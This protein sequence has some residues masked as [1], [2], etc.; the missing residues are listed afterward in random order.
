MSG[1]KQKV[2][3][4][5]QILGF[6]FSLAFLALVLLGGKYA[7]HQA[8]PYAVVCFGLSQGNFISLWNTAMGLAIVFGFAVLVYS[9]FYGRRFCGYLCPLGSLQE[10]IFSLRS[11]KYRIKHRR[12]YYTERK[13]SLL[14]YLIL[15]VNCLLTIL[16][17]NY[18]FIRLCPFYSLSLLPRL[19]WPGLILLGLIILRSF[20][21]EREWCR[22]LCPYAALLNAFQWLGEKIGI[23][24]LKVRRNLE[25]CTDCGICSLY[26]PMNI[27]LSE[28]EYVHNRNCIHCGQCSEKCPKAGT[29]NEEREC[30][31]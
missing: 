29:C 3:L 24:R 10:A 2:R 19:A 15:G 30:E 5:F 28:S 1:K 7:I 17:L 6:A 26:C 22:Y 4:L 23:R 20:F 13:L 18:I 9:M 16:G 12:P 31:N 11:R 8:C 21:G 14:K 25:R 27:N